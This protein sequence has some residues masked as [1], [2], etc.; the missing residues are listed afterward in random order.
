MSDTKCACITSPNPNLC[1]MCKGIAS[2]FISRLHVHAAIS[3]NSSHVP[4]HSTQET[5]KFSASNG[6]FFC[7]LLLENS[8]QVVPSGFCV[9]QNLL[10]ARID[11]AN[12]YAAVFGV[13]DHSVPSDNGIL[14]VEAFRCRCMHSG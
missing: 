10:P 13:G 6:C 11:G 8:P 14:L 4:H 7:S 1:D 12:R 2:D 3:H 9:I 5:L